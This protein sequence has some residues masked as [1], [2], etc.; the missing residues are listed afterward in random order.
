MDCSRVTELFSEYIDG[1]LDGETRRK[2][3]EHLAVCPSCAEELEA[4]RSCVSALTSL[5]RVE[6]PVDFFEKVHERIERR[7]G[8]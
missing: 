8:S 6:A 2:V 4:L 7:E 1:V 5:D 3:E